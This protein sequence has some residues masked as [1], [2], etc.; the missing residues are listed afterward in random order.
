MAMPVPTAAAAAAMPPASSRLVVRF[1]SGPPGSPTPS[2]VAAEPRLTAS[3]A[4]SRRSGGRARLLAVK[5]LVVEDD[6]RIAAAVR[7]GLEAEG[8]GVGVAADGP[9]GLWMAAE[10][11]YDVIVLD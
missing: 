11:T 8:F 5:V 9:E 6:A 10:G 3:S 1:M 4:V 7:R 2:H